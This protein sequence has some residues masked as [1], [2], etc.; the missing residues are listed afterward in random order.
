MKTGTDGQGRTVGLVYPFG[1]NHPK[2][3]TYVIFQSTA[4]EL[5]Y[6]GTGVTATLTSTT[7][8]QETKYHT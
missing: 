4:D 8:S 7:G 2:Q 3:G 6:D 1:Q 5:A